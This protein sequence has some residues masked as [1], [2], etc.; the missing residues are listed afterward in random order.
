MTPRRLDWQIVRPKLREIERLL[1]V[2]ESLEPI[3]VALL[4]QDVRTE[5][6]VER[7]LTLLVELAFSVNGHVGA[8]HLGRSP[9]SYADSF[10]LAAE[11]GAIGADLAARLRP[12]AATRTV[13]VH[14]YLETDR[15][16]VAAAVPR[17]VED[18]TD[19]RRQVAS[20]FTSTPG[21]GH[22]T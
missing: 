8:A 10:A 14:A 17:A 3:D 7:V 5:L 21:A 9:D 16:T 2:L 20:W 11:A 6:A 18:F 13:L 4:E 22:E 1:T 15:T 19:Y 12:A